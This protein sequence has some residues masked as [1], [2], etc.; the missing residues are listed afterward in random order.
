MSSGLKQ[1]SYRHVVDITMAAAMRKYVK[2][3]VTAN[4]ILS[5]SQRNFYSLQDTRTCKWL[6]DALS[7]DVFIPYEKRQFL[8]QYWLSAIMLH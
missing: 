1:L 2:A 4:S 8:W 5:P 3:D 6:H 7:T